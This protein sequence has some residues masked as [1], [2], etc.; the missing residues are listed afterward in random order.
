MRTHFG[1]EPSGS[2]TNPANKFPE[3]AGLHLLYN[4]ICVKRP[5]RLRE[6]PI[7]LE[8]GASARIAVPARA[9]VAAA[10]LGVPK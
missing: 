10:D 4:T 5:R 1:S 3:E 6:Y 9:R 2:K 8:D 7:L